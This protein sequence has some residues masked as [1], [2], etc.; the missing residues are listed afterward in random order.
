MQNLQEKI[1]LSKIKFTNHLKNLKNMLSNKTILVY[2]AGRLFETAV[3]AGRGRGRGHQ[4]L[5]GA[6]SML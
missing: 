1:Y 6:C 5:L 3:M 2:G 4:S